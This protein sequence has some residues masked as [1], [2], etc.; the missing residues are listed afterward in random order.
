MPKKNDRKTETMKL[1]AVILLL[2]YLLLKLICLLFTPQ[3]MRWPLRLLLLAF[4]V[5]YVMSLKNS[6]RSAAPVRK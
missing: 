6:K 4:A 2:A 1:R 5:T 3:F